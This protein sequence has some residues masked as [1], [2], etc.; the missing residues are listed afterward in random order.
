ML[1]KLTKITTFVGRVITV[2]TSNEACGEFQILDKNRN[3]VSAKNGMRVTH[4]NR[5]DKGTIIGVARCL[6]GKKVL[7]AIFD[8]RD[9]KATYSDPIWYVKA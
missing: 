1:E 8:G 9:G 2:N 6:T 3:M 5:N 7:W 4:P